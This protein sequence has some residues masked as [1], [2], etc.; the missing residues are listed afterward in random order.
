[1]LRGPPSDFATQASGSRCARYLTSGLLFRYG[2]LHQRYA[3]SCN[4]SVTALTA[5]S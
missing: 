2:Q 1:M 5:M 3:L 4:W